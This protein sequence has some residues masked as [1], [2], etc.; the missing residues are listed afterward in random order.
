[1]NVVLSY[2]TE[3]L[4]LFSCAHN[5]F[6]VYMLLSAVMRILSYLA[7]CLVVYC[8]MCAGT[9]SPYQPGLTSQPQLE[10]F[11]YS[12]DVDYQDA[13]YVPTGEAGAYYGTHGEVA[14]A[15]TGNTSQTVLH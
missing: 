3:R 14:M 11:T 5:A 12:A 13:G 2:D 8:A 7:L 9:I 1:M 6:A 4:H 15:P 10:H